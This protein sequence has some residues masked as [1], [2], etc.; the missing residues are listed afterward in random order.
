MA[1]MKTKIITAQAAGIAAGVLLSAILFIGS[2]YVRALRIVALLPLAACPAVFFWYQS[3]GKISNDKL[4]LGRL[5]AALDESEQRFQMTF[6]QAAGMGLTTINGE[7]VRVNKSL[8][9]LLGYSEAEL[10]KMTLHSLSHPEDADWLKEQLTNLLRG[11]IAS[12]QLE[13]RFLRKDAEVV[14]VVLSATKIAEGKNNSAK[15][16]LQMQD[17]TDRKSVEERLL[18]E[19]L[20]DALTGLP[21]RALYMDHL[22]KAVARWKRREHGAFAVLFLDLDGFKGIN[23]TLGH[24]AGDQLLVEF[25]QRLIANTRPGDTFARLG[26]DE[27]SILLD[28]LNDLNDAIIAVKRLQQMLKEPFHVSGRELFVTSSI[29]VA[30]STPEYVDPEEI[31]RHADAAMY[32][33]KKLGKGRYEVFDRT[34]S[35]RLERQSQIETD[36]SRAVERAELF[37]EYQPIV[38]LETGRIAGF[39]ALLRWQHPNLGMI[40]PPD[41]ITVAEATGAIVP[42]GEWVLQESCRQTREWQKSCPQN[43]PLYMSVNLSVKQFTQPNL[44][45]QVA[46][47]LHNGGLD[48]SSL[49]L[50]ITESMLMN[51][52]SAIRMLSQLNALGVGISIDDFGTG[53]SSLSY[54]HRLPFSNLKIDRSFVNS[55]SGNK[56]SFE[57]VRTIITL[58][59]SLNLTIVAEGIETNEQVEILRDLN[60]EYGQGHFF[61]KALKVEWAASLLFANANIAFD[62]QGT[63]PAIPAPAS[64]LAH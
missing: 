2:F 50:E 51:A 9:K 58:A 14:W 24:L 62:T 63:R 52:D 17:I 13:Q 15:M 30:L 25:T 37:L 46:I 28:D 47:A 38:A 3:K 29:G 1:R 31:L 55:M 18:H 36:L 12:V 8:C 43:P 42:I 44:V 59:R 10:L 4:E 26:G 48:P 45:E 23:D 53:Y 35:K 57:I 11:S 40:A 56:E 6:N 34:T 21:N 49:K 32:R 27:F 7:W 39:E 64:L 54:L 19:A 61:S 22:R 60:C 20:H 33:A 41:F 5:S 16:I